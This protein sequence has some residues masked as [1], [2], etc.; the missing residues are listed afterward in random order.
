MDARDFE[1][2]DGICIRA[3]DADKGEL[4]VIKRTLV[5]RNGNRFKLDRALRENA[6]LPG[7]PTVETLFPL[8][9]G[10]NIADVTIENCAGRQ[11][12]QQHQPGR[13]FCRLRLVAGLHPHDPAQ[14]SPRATITATA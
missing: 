6:F 2:G 7:E 11:Q 1:I 3:K 5:A 9:S 13:Q 14:P 10:E 12:G 8:F 4:K